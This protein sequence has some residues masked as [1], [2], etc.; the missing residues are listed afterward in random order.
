M[1]LASDAFNTYKK[2][3]KVTSPM[4][5]L[6]IEGAERAADALSKAAN[7]DLHALEME[8][9]KQQILLQVAQAQARIAQEMAI[10][11][12][13]DNAEEVEIEEFYDTSGK[14]GIGA[15]IDAKTETVT[16]NIGGEGRK[17]T[18]RIYH[19]KGWREESET[20]TQENL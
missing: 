1:S 2:V 4:S 8:A 9:A 10:A 13:I 5:W 7:K 15:N 3:M 14:A 18:K 11:R 16:A 19:F 6:V 12:R 20:I 17:I